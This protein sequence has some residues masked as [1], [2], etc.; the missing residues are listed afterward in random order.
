MAAPA[1]QRAPS[2]RRE[3]GGRP[4]IEIAGVTKVYDTGG[5]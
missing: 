3:A 4:V 2:T 1:T 5:N